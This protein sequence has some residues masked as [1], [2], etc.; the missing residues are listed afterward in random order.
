MSFLRMGFV[1]IIGIALFY[2]L[3]CVVGWNKYARLKKRIRISN[4]NAKDEKVKI[5]T[6]Y[7]ITLISLITIGFIFTKHYITTQ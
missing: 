3:M 1:I 4:K 2:T 5:I 7:I 6:I